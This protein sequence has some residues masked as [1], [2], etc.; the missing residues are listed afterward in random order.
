MSAPADPAPADP[1]PAVLAA[2][3]HDLDNTLPPDVLYGGW[4]S[5]ELM[6]DRYGGRHRFHEQVGRIRKHRQAHLLLGRAPSEGLT[7][8]EEAAARANPH[9]LWVYC[10]A[11]TVQATCGTACHLMIDF[12]DPRHLACLPDRAFSGITIDAGVMHAFEPTAGTIED[13]FRQYR[14]VMRHGA[15]MTIPQSTM[16]SYKPGAATTF[17]PPTQLYGRAFTGIVR[18]DDTLPPMLTRRLADLAEMA[19]REPISPD[20][21]IPPETFWEWIRPRWKSGTYPCTLPVSW[22]LCEGDMDLLARL[23]DKCAEW[24]QNDPPPPIDG[25][26]SQAIDLQ[27]G[28]SVARMC[29]IGLGTRYVTTRECGNSTEG[30]FYRCVRLPSELT[31]SREIAWRARYALV[32]RHTADGMTLAYHADAGEEAQKHPRY[33]EDG[34]PPPVTFP[35]QRAHLL[36]VPG[37][38]VNALMRRTARELVV[39]HLGR[40]FIPDH[41]DAAADTV[42]E[43]TTGSSV[44]LRP[45]KQTLHFSRAL[46]MYLHRLELELEPDG[47]TKAQMMQLGLREDVTDAFLACWEDGDDDREPTSYW[48]TA[49]CDYALFDQE[50]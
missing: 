32:N 26:L 49:A 46:S 37:M 27:I 17:D 23:V 25:M 22:R 13:V 39:E 30:S 44:E 45:S 24:Q 18:L 48:A 9:I 20:G 35:S 42:L 50:I 43:Y 4:I 15:V 10:S 33:P 11:D 5:R 31:L 8:R 7:V 3:Q 6:V 41:V 38:D 14:R 1:A 40:C 16:S 34:T 12:F 28:F 36:V 47:D 2:P 21:S 29:E 19:G